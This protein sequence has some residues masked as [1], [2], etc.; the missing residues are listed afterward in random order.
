MKRQIARV[1]SNEITRRASL[2]DSDGLDGSP[3]R[4]V[5]GLCIKL[6]LFV[7]LFFAI[8][9]CGGERDGVSLPESSEGGVER[10]SITYDKYPDMI[11]DQNK[12]Y[13]AT[14]VTNKGTIVF[15]LFTDEAPITVNNFVFLS[16]QGYYDGVVFHRIIKNFMIQGGDPTGTGGGGP[17]YRF[18]DEPVTREYVPGTLAMANAGPNTNGSQ[19]FIVQGKTAGLPKSYNIFGIVSD[20]LDVVDAIADTPVASSASGERSKPVNS[21]VI[22]TVTVTESS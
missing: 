18:Q 4:N 13:T 12:E 17:G 5:I 7:V 9:S 2:R 16:N 20:G 22:E 3:E 14:M 15:K 6:G 8:A 1:G 19:F 10:M 21:V 11:I